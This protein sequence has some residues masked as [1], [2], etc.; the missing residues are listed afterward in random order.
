[1]SFFRFFTLSVFLLALFLPSL[2]VYAAAEMGDLIKCPD[3]SSVYYYA[4]DG[5][6]YAFP[7]E[8]VYFSWYENFD[9]VKTI[10]CED[11]AS[12]NLAGLVTYQAGTR[13][14]KLQ[15]ASTVYV[16]EP[17]GLLRPMASEEQAFELYGDF[18][19]QRVDDLPDVFFSHYEV[20]AMLEN[21]EIPEGMAFTDEEG[22][23]WRMQ[24]SGML[25]NID[26]VI[27][28][29]IGMPV[30]NL[31]LEK[32]AFESRMG[33]S[34]EAMMPEEQESVESLLVDFQTI[35]TDIVVDGSLSFEEIDGE[36]A[37]EN[38]DSVAPEEDQTT[39]EDDSDS[40]TQEEYDALVE[41]LESDLEG[42]DEQT[43]Q[44]E[45][46]GDEAQVLDDTL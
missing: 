23:L 2:P 16:V 18:W 6:R 14:V 13:L 24:N 28:S 19:A 17:Q 29:G 8:Q 10:S 41:D 21:N 15:T 38:D 33:L 20:G 25:A 26:E 42:L 31:S 22:S 30:K 4:Q 11:L 32:E 9:G 36:E 44:V 37:V 34:L 1:M 35:V 43:Q 45:E 46:V 39:V 40:L 27:A 7:N 3:F 12:A 5:Q